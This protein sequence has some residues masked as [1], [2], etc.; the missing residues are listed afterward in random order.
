MQIARHFGAPY[1]TPKEN[2]MPYLKHLYRLKRL[3]LVILFLLLT[4][5]VSHAQSPGDMIADLGFRPAVNGF[6]FENYG[7]GH[8]D[9]TAVEVRRLFGDIACDSSP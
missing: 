8:D 4:V 9:L 3:T 6:G 2:Y 7:E 5:E 1:G